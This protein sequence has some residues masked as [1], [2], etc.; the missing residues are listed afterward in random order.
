MSAHIYAMINDREV[1]QENALISIFDLGLLRGLA[2]F[3]LL[4]TYQEKPLFLNHHTKR[5]IESAKALSLHVDISEEDIENRVLH[6]LQKRKGEE[7]MIRLLIT[8]G[9]SNDRILPSGSPNVIVAVMP[10]EKPNAH[11]KAHGIQLMSVPQTRFMPEVKTTSYLPAILSIQQARQQGFDD[12][13]YVCEDGR[14]TESSTSNIFFVKNHKLYTPKT[15]LLK[16]ITREIII[17]EANRYFEVNEC[18]IFL[19]QLPQFEEAFLTS[20]IKET[21]PK[22]GRAHV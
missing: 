6:L 15:E 16:G 14:V 1:S 3:E 12:I 18:D 2:V 8:G 21:L 13:L 11:L 7:S 22:I 10:V 4:R 20:S 17:Q 9:I 5:L 19:D